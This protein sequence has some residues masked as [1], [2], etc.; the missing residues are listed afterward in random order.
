MF[1]DLRMANLLAE[2]KREELARSYQSAN[3]RPKRMSSRAPEGRSLSRPPAVR[4][5]L[6]GR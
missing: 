4:R 1:V 2:Q 3:R 5:L 6:P